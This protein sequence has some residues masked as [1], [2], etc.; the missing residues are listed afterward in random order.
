MN[1]VNDLI[2]VNSIFGNM[3]TSKAWRAGCQETLP[4]NAKRESSEEVEES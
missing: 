2:S 1:I 4:L 3:R